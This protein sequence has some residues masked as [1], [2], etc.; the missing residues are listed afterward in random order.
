MKIALPLPVFLGLFLALLG[1]GCAPMKEYVV[2][3][4]VPQKGVTPITSA[5]STRVT[6]EMEDQRK[7]KN[8]IGQAE[9]YGSD[10]PTVTGLLM[11]SNDVPAFVKSAIESELKNRGFDTNGGDAVVV[12]KLKRFES[13]LSAYSAAGIEVDGTVEMDVAVQRIDGSSPYQ[14]TIIGDFD[15]GASIF[16]AKPKEGIIEAMNK[17]MANL[18]SDQDF[19]NALIQSKS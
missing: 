1:G 7:E 14:K 3:S 6:V 9:A 5:A 18:F 11:T 16:K 12:V 8:N 4:Y 10:T 15:R 2:L 17:A 13:N 19:I